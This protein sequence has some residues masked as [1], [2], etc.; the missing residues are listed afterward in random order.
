MRNL[1]NTIFPVFTLGKMQTKKHNYSI[2]ISHSY[3]EY[4]EHRID[5]ELNIPYE[6]EKHSVNTIAFAM[7]P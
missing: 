5:I 6:Y 1:V 2:N 4:R 3:R 7:K